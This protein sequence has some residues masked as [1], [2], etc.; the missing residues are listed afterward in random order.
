MQ[1]LHAAFAGKEYLLIL[2][3]VSSANYDSYTFVFSYEFKIYNC[4]YLTQ[5]FPGKSLD[6]VLA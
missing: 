5:Q 6:S 4:G 2:Q 3:E 1:H